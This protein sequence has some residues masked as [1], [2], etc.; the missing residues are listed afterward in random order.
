MK[1]SSVGRAGW[2]GD[3]DSLYGGVEGGVGGRC[4]LG[5]ACPCS[6]RITAVAFSARYDTMDGDTGSMMK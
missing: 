3:L 2:R 5:W 6:Q 1:T 4:L